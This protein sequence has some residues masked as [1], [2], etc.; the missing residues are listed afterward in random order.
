MTSQETIA[1]FDKYV[2]G[3]YRR[4][5]V[6]LVRGEGYVISTAPHGGANAA[7]SRAT[8][9]SAGN[10]APT[11]AVGTHASR[12]TRGGGA[13]SSADTAHSADR[14]CLLSAAGVSLPAQPPA[15]AL[16]HQAEHR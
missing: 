4:Y 9:E 8:P 11:P 10:P 16:A 7:P 12:A 14:A 1:I 5:P 3:N 6:S 13:T 15:A 2:I